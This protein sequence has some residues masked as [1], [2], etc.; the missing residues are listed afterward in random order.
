MTLFLH[1]H[2]LLSDFS[3][4]LPYTVKEK[5]IIHHDNDNI[6]LLNNKVWY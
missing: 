3:I 2:E 4:L 1:I 5:I 6:F